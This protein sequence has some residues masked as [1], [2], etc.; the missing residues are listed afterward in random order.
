MGSFASSITWRSGDV[1]KRC[2]IPTSQSFEESLSSALARRGHQGE[3]E[4]KQTI[5][6]FET[7]FVPVSGHPTRADPGSTN[8]VQTYTLKR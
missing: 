5:L 4:K 6:R 7:S 2:S 3:V 1:M 8:I